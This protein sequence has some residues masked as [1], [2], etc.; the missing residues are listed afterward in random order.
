MNMIHVLNTWDVSPGNV[1][2]KGRMKGVEG[3][4]ARGKGPGIEKSKPIFC[5]RT[6]QGRELCR[7]LYG[8]AV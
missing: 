3:S 4:Y 6:V 7:E 1:V 5:L 2:L 8:F